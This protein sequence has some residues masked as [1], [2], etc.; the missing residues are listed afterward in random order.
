MN[1][2]AKK[3]IRKT[4]CADA[5]QDEFEK[6]IYLSEQYNLDPLKGEMYFQRRGGDKAT[7][8]TT[9]DGYLKIAH[10]HP[11]FDG[12]ESDAVY[13]G[14]KLTKR[15]DGSF[16]IEYGEAHLSFD[17]SQLRGAF[18]NVYRKDWSKATAMFASFDDYNK[19]FI[20]KSGSVAQTPWSIY[21]NAMIIK[22][23]ES[24]ALKRAF[25]I[26]GLVTKEE[27]ALVD[28][29]EDIDAVAL[30]QAKKDL[31]D[32]LTQKNIS[33]DDMRKIMGDITGKTDSS[34]LNAQE[35]SYIIDY[36]GGL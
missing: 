28:E 26:S 21:P 22:V 31:R 18:C 30:A 9:R 27:I 19:Q 34:S 5:S 4:I 14:D 16:L 15:E 23:A 20:N 1:E 17:K 8:F 13:I 24:N 25:S 3:I 12:L 6:F 33:K 35:I 10:N 2:S 11:Q 29:S 32:L 36:I 7:I